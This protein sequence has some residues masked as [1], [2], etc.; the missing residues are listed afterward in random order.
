MYINITKTKKSILFLLIFMCL[1]IF[2]SFYS[3]KKYKSLS[4]NN[5]NFYDRNKT[6]KYIYLLNDMFDRSWYLYNNFVKPIDFEKFKCSEINC[7]VTT[8]VSVLSSISLFDAVLFHGARKWS[9]KNTIPAERNS[10]QLYVVAIL[11]S[12]SNTEHDLKTNANF[13]N[14]TLTYR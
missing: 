2:Y 5:I 7:V 12:P 11:E 13:F 4:P 9:L 14:W 6:I 10:N 8:N 1:L 3:T